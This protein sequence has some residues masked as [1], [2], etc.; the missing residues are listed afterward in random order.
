MAEREHRGRVEPVY[1]PDTPRKLVFGV[2]R[3]CHLCKGKG[4]KDKKICGACKGAGVIDESFDRDDQ[5]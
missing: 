1:K 5:S 2:S 4:S 3:V